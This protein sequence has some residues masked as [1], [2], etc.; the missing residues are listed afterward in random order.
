MSTVQERVS[1]EFMALEEKMMKLN[2]FIIRSEVYEGLDA[3]DQLLLR[4]QASA[5][6]QY[7]AILGERLDRFQKA[8]T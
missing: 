3:V 7:A 2:D 4:L 1:E 6:A 8:M 5:M